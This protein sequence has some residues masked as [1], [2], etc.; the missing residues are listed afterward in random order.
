LLLFLPLLIILLFH[1]ILTLIY[2]R[3]KFLSILIL[4]N[5]DQVTLTSFKH[6]IANVFLGSHAIDFTVD[7]IEVHLLGQSVVLGIVLI[8]EYQSL[9]MVQNVVVYTNVIAS[10]LATEFHALFHSSAYQVFTI[11][12]ETGNNFEIDNWVY[13]VFGNSVGYDLPFLG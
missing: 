2:R 5:I 8:V 6:K 4:H 11:S 3:C 13:I 9:I 1:F 7:Q 10:V 12:L